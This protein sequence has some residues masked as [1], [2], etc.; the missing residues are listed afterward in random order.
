[1]V[2]VNGSGKHSSFL[3]QSNNLGRNFFSIGHGHYRKT[4]ASVYD[5][6]FL[7][8]CSKFI[9]W[10]NWLKVNS[11]PDFR[12]ELDPLFKLGVQTHFQSSRTDLELLLAFWSQPMIKNKNILLLFYKTV[13]LP[14][15]P[16]NGLNRE[17]WLKEKA[18]S[19]VDFLKPARF[20]Y[21][22]F[23]KF[24]YCSLN[25]TVFCKTFLVHIYS[26]FCKVDRPFHYC[27]LFFHLHKNGLA[28]TQ[29]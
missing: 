20:T 7:N 22:Y 23:F 1:M 5:D 25:N 26:L 24:T 8:F 6:L 13:K 4:I 18:Q 21:E 11:V 9:F 29:E 16:V 15:S 14:R 12:P 10:K 2:G 17:H 27:T 28:Y 19:T 3:G